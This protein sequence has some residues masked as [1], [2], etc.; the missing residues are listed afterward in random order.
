MGVLRERSCL[1]PNQQT[2]VQRLVENPFYYLQMKMGGGKT[3]TVLTAYADLK[4]DFMV[5]R[6]LVI[7]TK[8]VATTVWDAEPTLW[9]HLAHIKVSVIGGTEKQ[10]IAAVNAVANIY[11]IG[12]ENVE[13]LCEH[14][15]ETWKWD[16][17][18]FDES[19]SFKNSQSNRFRA[20]VG[21]KI[22]ATK[23]KPEKRMVGVM[24]KVYRA[25]CMSGT[26]A[27]N[28]LIDVW[29][30]YRLLRCY[31]L[32][33]NI[34]AFRNYWFNYDMRQ[35]RYF[36][37]DRALREIPAAVADITYVVEDYSG[38]PDVVYNTVRIPVDASLAAQYKR[39]KREKLLELVDTQITALNA[40]AL[41]GKLC[42]FSNGAV[43]DEDRGVHDI[44]KL[45]LDALR[46]IIDQAQGQPV[47]V[48]YAFQHDKSR[49][50][51]HIPGAVALSG[52]VKAIT[53]RWNA[54]EIPVLVAH[55]G[56]CGHGLNLQ[57]GGSIIVWFGLSPNL[58]YF[59]QMNARLARSGQKN[60]VFIHSL[61][62]DKT[63]D[64]KVMAML[65][66]KDHEQNSFAQAVKEM[67]S[68][69][70]T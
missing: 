25:T 34:T 4:R 69:L 6:A 3:V 51:K 35:H 65:E 16:W 53:N 39:F 19:D 55:P 43:Y 67:L 36:P 21:G 37:K 26:P 14:F 27:P 61:V 58:A 11:T 47:L 17:I 68:E 10:R 23:N 8:N 38:M 59:M 57:H 22:P 31:K 40:A 1:R 15:G 9:E 20:L 41:F 33:H 70:Q 24:D 42:Q 60:T 64:D 13:W 56:S 66:R 48:A 29:A 62:T 28:G 45:K 50:L 5:S 32:L 49:I 46:D 2:G 44:H 54:G 30:Q 52:N 18:I 63:E 12:R 7:S